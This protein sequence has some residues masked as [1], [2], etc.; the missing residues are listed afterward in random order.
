MDCYL[1]ILDNVIVNEIIYLIW[2]EILILSLWLNWKLFFNVFWMKMFIIMFIKSIKELM[3]KS[4][5]KYVI[6]D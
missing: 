5:I 1:F 3:F 6:K 2:L 4:D